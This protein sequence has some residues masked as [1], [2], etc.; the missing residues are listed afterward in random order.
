MKKRSLITLVLALNSVIIPSLV[1]APIMSGS[2]LLSDKSNLL[3]G[4]SPLERSIKE[5]EGIDI[6]NYKTYDFNKDE[7][8]ILLTRMIF[9]EAEGLLNEEKIWVAYTSINR[10][11]QGGYGK[12]LKEVILSPYQYSC[13]NKDKDSSLFL[14]D[15]LRHDSKEFF[16]SL[17][18]ARD[19]LDGKIKDPTKEAISYYAPKL[20]KKPDWANKMK[21][22]KRI[23]G[24]QHIFYR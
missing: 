4:D 12:N 2:S 11:K 16:T 17:Q 24:F 5:K 1:E 9:G 10:L 15:P 20:V 19:I 21:E 3:I 22:I 14:K 13:F 18:I 6:L 23:P 7:D 8:Q